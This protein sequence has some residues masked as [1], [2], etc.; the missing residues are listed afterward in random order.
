MT[1]SVLVV[2]DNDDLREEIVFQ[3]DMQGLKVRGARDAQAMD[4]LLA[5]QPCDILVLDLNLPGENGFSIA[6]RR[7]DPQR[8]GI[9][10]LTARDAIDDKLQC[11]DNGA[12][13]YLVKPVDRRELTACIKVLFRRVAAVGQGARAWQLS[14]QQRALLAPDG[15]MLSLTA[16]DLRVLQFLAERP[17]ATRSRADLV[18]VLGIDF[19]QAPEG[20]TNTVISRLRQKLADF[21]PELR[22]MSWRN[23]GYSY[24]G[25][26]LECPPAASADEV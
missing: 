22:I 1:P 20:R 13:L 18:R 2:E 21:D 25:P 8:M 5:E 9:I 10:I 16:Q 19:M 23:Q 6:R 17:G 26:G 3:L 12:D 15:R 4:A 11:F 7:C 24:V 14:V